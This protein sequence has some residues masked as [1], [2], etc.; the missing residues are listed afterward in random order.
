MDISFYSFQLWSPNII[1]EFRKE[2]IEFLFTRTDWRPQEGVSH[3]ILSE[4]LIFKSQGLVLQAESTVFPPATIDTNS[5]S[6][7]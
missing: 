7:S 1:L 3:T 6:S 2:F 5:S 4:L